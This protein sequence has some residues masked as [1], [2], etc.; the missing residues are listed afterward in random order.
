MSNLILRPI[1]KSS[2]K[3][4]KSKWYSC[5][6]FEV[7][8]RWGMHSDAVVLKLKSN[9]SDLAKKKLQVSGLLFFLST[10]EVGASAVEA[11]GPGRSQCNIFVLKYVL[12]YNLDRK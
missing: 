11:V 9:E 3:L 7:K 12:V 8:E 1:K 2:L 6:S 4:K 10:H 5:K